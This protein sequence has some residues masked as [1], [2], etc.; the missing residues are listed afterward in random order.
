MGATIELSKYGWYIPWHY[1]KDEVAFQKERKMVHPA[2]ATVTYLTTCSGSPTVVFGERGTLLSYPQRGNH[3]VFSGTLLHGVPLS[4]RDDSRAATADKRERITL[5]INIWPIA[6]QERE[7]RHRS[8]KPEVNA[9]T[10][11][12]RV[13]L[14]EIIVNQPT[15]SN[16]WKPSAVLSQISKEDLKNASVELLA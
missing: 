10:S 13:S 8:L 1:D 11:M 5:L 7:I 3:M 4:L 14:E 9:M 12:A 6:P 15:T 16:T 2:I